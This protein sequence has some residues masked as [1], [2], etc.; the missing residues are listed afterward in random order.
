MNHSSAQR[1]SAEYSFR[2]GAILANSRYAAMDAG[3]SAIVAL[4]GLPQIGAAAVRQLRQDGVGAGS[5][6]RDEAEALCMVE[7]S[8]ALKSLEWDDFFIEAITSHCVWDLRPTGVVN[9][10]QGEWLIAMADRARTPNAFAVLVNVLAAA[11]RVP[12]WLTAAVKARAAR[13]W[14]GADDARALVERQG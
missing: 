5:L 13:G 7:R 4:A 1:Q 11:H 3:R 12:L 8:A 2:A 9:E 10:A 6:S 14:P